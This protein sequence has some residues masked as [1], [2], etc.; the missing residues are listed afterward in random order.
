MKYVTMTVAILTF[1][2]A[3]MLSAGAAE[4][5][6][7]SFPD[8]I[9]LDGTALVLN[10]LGLRLATSFKVNVY[11]AALYVTAKSG[12]SQA[13]LDAAT[14]KR[15]VLHFLRHV[16]GK[17]LTEA[18][19]E[20]FEKNVPNQIPALK[21]RIEKIKSYTT[22]MK[23]GQELGFTYK[24]GAGIVVDIDGAEVGTVEGDDFAKAFLAIWLGPE[25]PNQGLKDG[26]LGV[27]TL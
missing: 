24:P 13:I 3:A 4:L 7:V 12:D 8:E 6:G 25:P 2:L 27:G 19:D 18:W 15:L 1:V 20:G 23:K 21:E 14:P 26:L 5:K 16:G 9:R 10:G 17:D 11:V 22:D